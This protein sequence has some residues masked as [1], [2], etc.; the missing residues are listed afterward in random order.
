MKIKQQWPAAK[1]SSARIVS[2]TAASAERQ[3]WPERNGVAEK[4]AI[5]SGENQQRK[6][7]GSEMKA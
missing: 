6:R 4:K 3:Q 5:N 7:D 2:E 1:K